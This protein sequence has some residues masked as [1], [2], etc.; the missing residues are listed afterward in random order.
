MSHVSYPKSL[1]TIMPNVTCLIPQ[2]FSHHN[3]QSHTSESPKVAGT[4]TSPGLF[5]V[6]PGK[7]FA[8]HYHCLHFHHANSVVSPEHITQISIIFDRSEKEEWGRGTIQSF[9]APPDNNLHRFAAT[10]DQPFH[11]EKSEKTTIASTTTTTVC[12][13][14]HQPQINLSREK[15]REKKREKTE[16]IATTTPTTT[17]VC[18]T[19][20]A[21][22][23]QPF[24]REKLRA[25]FHS[26]RSY[27]VY[28]P[29]K[30]RLGDR[31]K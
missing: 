4:S 1:V 9:S 22:P 14:F 13:G 2:K 28:Q 3:A 16:K 21:T 23:D 24:Q 20:T 17:T 29:K 25:R 18:I 10:L 30:I 6:G 19:T 31:S 5:L 27:T 7:I 15:K 11:K 26:S 8:L 12:I